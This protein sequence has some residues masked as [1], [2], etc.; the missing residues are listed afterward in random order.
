MTRNKFI[1][2][3]ATG[4]MGILLFL[5]SYKTQRVE[6]VK[7]QLLF[8]ALFALYGALIVLYRKVN[9]QTTI[10][11]LFLAGAVLRGLLL[12]STPNLSDD[13]YR[14]TWDGYLSNKGYPVFE[15]TP[16]EFILQH[17][18]D[19]LAQRLFE[20][21]NSNFTSGMN[22][23]DYYSIYPTV[24]Q[25]VFSFTYWITDSPNKGN[26]RVMKGILLL[27]DCFTFFILIR[28]LRL[29]KK[30]EFLSMLYWLNP[31][32][33][34]E[35]VGNLHFDGIALTFLLFSYYLLV[36]G[37]LVGSGFA[38]AGAIATKLNPV[39]LACISWR[40]LKFSKLLLWGMITGIVSLLLLAAVLRMEDLGNF[41]Q[42]F[43]LYLY[44]FQF[45]SSLVF[46][47]D[48]LF[49]LSGLEM[50]MA[51]FPMIVLLAI[52]A[53]NLVKGRWTTSEKLILAYTIYFVF[54]STVNPWYIAILLPFAIISDWKF[55]IIWTYL[56]VWSY[57]FYHTDAVIQN[58]WLILTEYLLLAVFI[59][60]DLARKPTSVKHD[61]KNT[62]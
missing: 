37:K 45:N 53:L 40:E 27:F 1:L 41:H 19:T 17:P 18:D 15:S 59:W 2:L 3:L 16:R 20:A 26:I 54:G 13:F 23:R 30:P 29:L 32:V 24:N 55:P 14:F 49:G 22:S 61:Q 6:H 51:Y 48:T 4:F 36:Q 47:S 58:G 43:R 39:F 62:C 7:V 33:I 46:L 57:S 9:W 44:V 42:S 21:H 50:A 52:L 10:M 8:A 12:F 34:V 5:L 25:A 56:V 38:L 11:Y 31:L 35:F 60:W 28:L